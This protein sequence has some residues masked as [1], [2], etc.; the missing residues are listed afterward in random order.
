MQKYSETLSK[1]SYLVQFEARSRE[2]LEFSKHD[3]MQSFSTTLLT[4]C[5]EKVICMK[6][7]GELY[8]KVRLTPIVPRVVLKS[9]SQ[10]GQQDPQSQ[11]TRSSWAPSSDS[12]NFG[13]ICSNIVDYIMLGVLLSAVEQQDTSRENKVKK[14]IDK[15]E[16]QKHK[17]S[18]RR[19]STSSAKNRRI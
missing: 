5:M 2:I 3:L 10:H 15:F 12:K 16:I 11:D 14:L 1:Y 13:E 4:A 8:L 17:D 19:R 7:K 18:R 9:N 6:T